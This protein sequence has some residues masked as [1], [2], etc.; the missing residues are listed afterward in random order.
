MG[1]RFTLNGK[2]VESDVPGGRTLLDH[3]REDLMEIG[4]LATRSARPIDDVRASAECRRAL[5]PGLFYPGMYDT[6]TEA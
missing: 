2:P 3:L 6:L 1:Y 5:I 4:E